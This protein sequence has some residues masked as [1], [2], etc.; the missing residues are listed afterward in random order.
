MARKKKV[1][2]H[3]GEIYAIN[4]K[5]VVHSSKDYNKAK[6]S[7]AKNKR[8][9]MV[10][11][12]KS[13]KK[14]QVSNMTTKATKKQVNRKQRVRLSETYPNKTSYVNTDTV[15]KS[16]ITKKHFKVGIPPLTKPQAKAKP[17]DI[18]SYQK[19]RKAR[20]R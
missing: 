15:A 4:P 6:G 13:S 3:V 9:V 2:T 7:H 12:E 18:K 14:V 19:A 8:L 20:G 1:K 10:G 16:K 5:H 17:G 11:V